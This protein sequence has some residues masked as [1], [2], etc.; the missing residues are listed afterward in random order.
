[1]A[2]SEVYAIT[3]RTPGLAD[4]AAFVQRA[5]AQAAA[6]G[7]VA[8][9]TLQAG[10]TVGGGALSV[11][12]AA[13]QLAT[14]AIRAFVQAVPWSSLTASLPTLLEPVL[15]VTDAA[16]PPM[17]GALVRSAAATLVSM[18]QRI[19]AVKASGAP[20]TPSAAA[21]RPPAPS[22]DPT[23]RHTTTTTTTTAPLA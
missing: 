15:K 1:M 11:V 10:A 6:V 5:V 12:G 20:P 8:G 3:D 2:I 22:P 13:V 16:L 7:Q 4:T 18:Q 17:A 19:Q 21:P 23:T 14:P 9:S